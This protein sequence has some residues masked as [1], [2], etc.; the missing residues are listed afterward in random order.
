MREKTNYGNWDGKGSLLD[1][2]CGAA[3]LTVRCAKAFPEAE[4]TAIDY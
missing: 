4:I 3:A 2:G 1:I